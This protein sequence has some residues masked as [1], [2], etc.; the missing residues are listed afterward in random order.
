MPPKADSSA[1]GASSGMLINGKQPT[2][3]D[4]ELIV[5][6]FEH[7]N[8]KIDCDWEAIAT[9]LGHSNVR[10]TKERWRQVR[11]KLG[12]VEGD[13]NANANGAAGASGSGPPPATPTSTKRGRG[14]PAKLNLSTAGEPATPTGD[15]EE[16][17]E[18]ALGASPVKK[19]RAS[20]K[21]KKAAA[22]NNADPETDGN[23]EAM[24][25][26]VAEIKTEMDNDESPLSSAPPSQAGEAGEV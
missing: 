24:V 22:Q 9:K 11:Q 6:I 1:D 21:K 14:R 20:P 5:S 15:G 12:I 17:D 16:V 10:V 23:A 2:P 25:T 7:L 3:K 18:L 26:P 8:V 4:L 19:K 13:G